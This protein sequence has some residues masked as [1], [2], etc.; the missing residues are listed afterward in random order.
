MKNFMGPFSS[1]MPLMND[2]KN[3]SQESRSNGMSHSDLIDIGA[4]VTQ[5]GSKPATE[6]EI[7]KLINSDSKNDSRTDTKGIKG[8][9][10]SKRKVMEKLLS[11]KKKTWKIKVFLHF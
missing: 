3:I 7:E 5:T 4:K 1:V 6:T 10:G 8:K 9:V 11:I 2:P